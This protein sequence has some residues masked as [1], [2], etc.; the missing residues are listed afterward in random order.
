MRGDH[1]RRCR[2]GG[3]RPGA[4]KIW[5]CFATVGDH[6]PAAIELKKTVGRLATY[7]QGYGDLMVSTN[8]WD[9]AV[10]ERFRADAVVSSVGGAI[11]AVA[12]T[13]QLEH[14]AALLPD[15]WLEPSATGSPSQCVDAVLGQFALGCDGVIMHGASPAELAPVMREY[16]QRQGR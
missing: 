1:S 13:E 7:L 12:T 11:D 5:S 9:P 15:S 4:V 10:L 16:R 6:L 2:R 8:H 14:I 3:S